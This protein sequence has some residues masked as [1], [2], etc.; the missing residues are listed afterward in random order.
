MEYLVI[1]GFCV[2][3]IAITCSAEWIKAMFGECIGNVSSAKQS[4]N[5]ELYLAGKLGK[6]Y[7]IIVI[8]P[9]F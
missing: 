5:Y 1:D 6:D 7:D 2:I 8:F 3:L 9:E 4:S